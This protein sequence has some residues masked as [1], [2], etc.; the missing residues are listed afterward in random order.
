[1][2][3]RYFVAVHLFPVRFSERALFGDD[4]QESYAGTSVVNSQFSSWTSPKDEGHLT[5]ILS[6]FSIESSS[7][8]S[9]MIF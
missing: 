9:K 6:D 4:D 8:K 3:S 7:E 1:V 2:K 5:G